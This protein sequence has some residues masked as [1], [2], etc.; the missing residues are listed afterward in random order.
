MGCYGGQR[1]LL[2]DGR[3]GAQLVGAALQ[4]EKGK[5]TKGSQEKSNPLAGALVGVRRAIRDK[6][7]LRCQRRANRRA[8]SH[9]Q[10]SF[11][12]FSSQEENVNSNKRAI[13]RRETMLI[14]ALMTTTTMRS[15]QTI[16][17]TQQRIA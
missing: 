3:T 17:K 11:E 15:Q 1:V 6:G 5:K 9:C 14:M 10:I 8:A 7:A 4:P 13:G 16:L 2:L 12:D